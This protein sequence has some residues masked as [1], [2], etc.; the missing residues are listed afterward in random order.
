MIQLDHYWSIGLW[1]AV[2]ILF[3]IAFD[4]L[5]KRFIITTLLFGI[6]FFAYLTAASYG[7][8][9][10]QSRE[11]QLFFNRGSL[12]FILI[13]L[14]CYS[15]FTHSPFIKYTKKPK[16]QELI[17]FPFIWSGFHQTS[18]KVFL[19]IALVINTASLVPFILRNGWTYF[20]EIW[21]LMTIFSITNSL[22]EELIWR[23]ALLSRFSE[24]LGE[25]WAV[26]I[27]SIG[28]GL[29]HYS[30]GIPWAVCIAFSIGGVF[31]G[32]ITVK[33]GSMIP[34]MVWHF[35]LNILMVSSGFILN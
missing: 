31:Y 29:Q 33:S 19:M 24:Q 32:G 1:A 2:A 28:F 27:T 17:H 22:L 8:A 11:L 5:M 30:L 23:G 7:D 13:P 20:E 34:A 15:F 6:G 16:W 9:Q 10:F 14:F 35:V 21:L 4:H 3:Y 25:Q 12:V 18:V 26:I